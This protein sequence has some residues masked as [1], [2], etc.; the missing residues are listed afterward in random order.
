MV[1]KTLK[2]KFHQPVSTVFATTEYEGSTDA[3]PVSHD[4]GRVSVQPS[5]KSMPSVSI[6][7]KFQYLHYNNFI[8]IITNSL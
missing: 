1:P 3:L 2:E 7:V 5:P 6:T 8:S 4:V